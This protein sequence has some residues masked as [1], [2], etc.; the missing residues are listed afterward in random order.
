MYNIVP[1]LSFQ[2]SKHIGSQLQGNSTPCVL[3]PVALVTGI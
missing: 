3:P 1:V 2:K